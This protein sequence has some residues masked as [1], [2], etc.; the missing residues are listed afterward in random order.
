MCIYWLLGGSTMKFS[1]RLLSIFLIPLMMLL[2]APLPAEAASAAVPVDEDHFPDAYFLSLV[3]GYDK[4]GS[5]YLS[6]E[7]IAAVTEM[8][9]SS[10]AS[11]QGISY[12]TSLEKLEVYSSAVTSLD[13]S[14]L[15]NLECLEVSADL[16]ELNLNGLVN[17]TKLDCRGNELTSLNLRSNTAL[18]EVYCQEN[19]LTSLRMEGLTKLTALD[20]EDNALTTLTLSDLTALETL[21]CGKNALTSLNLRE[22]RSLKELYCD[23]NDLGSLDLSA[24]SALES[25]R[26]FTNP[27]TSLKLGNLSAMTTLSCSSMA[28]TSLDVSGLPN[29]KVLY[30]NDNQLKSLDVCGLSKLQYLECYN[31]RLTSLETYG[32]TSLKELRCNNNQLSV[33]DISS[34]ENLTDLWAYDNSLTTLN[35]SALPVF[36]EL[37]RTGKYIESSDGRWYGYQDQVNLVFMYVD[38]NV[39]IDTEKPSGIEICLENFPDNAFCAHISANFDK[40]GDY[41]LSDEEIAAVTRIDGIVTSLK[42]F[43][44]IEHFTALTYISCQLTDISSLDL[45]GNPAVTYLNCSGCENLTSLDLSVNTALTELHCNNC[46][47][48][49]LNINGCS[50][51]K[52]L[53]CCNNQLTSLQLG[54]MN[55]LKTL[56]CQENQLTRLD[57]RTAP[58]ILEAVLDGTKYSS[59]IYDSYVNKDITSS[60]HVDKNVEL[61]TASK[62]VI[63]TQPESATAAEGGTANFRVTAGG[64][65]L[66]YQWQ[67]RT[68]TAGSWKAATATGN[69]TAVLK[70]P[71]TNSRNGYQ[72]RCVV[73]NAGGTVY[74][75]AVTL[76]VTPAKPVITGQPESATAAEGG[77]ANFRVTAGGSGL[78]YQWQ[79]RTG[80]AGSWKAATATGN[81]TAVLKVPATN[82]RNGYQYRCVVKNAGG[83]VYSKAAVLTVSVTVKTE[84]ASDSSENEEE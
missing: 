22:N 62:P 8:R 24:C 9:V 65:G 27:M 21:S 32:C 52:H 5:G 20:C 59:D 36:C 35:I 18:E 82:S 72:Y 43:E 78:S 29:L 63:K 16:T 3:S 67:Y 39:T 79:Y 48:K 17:L 38:K 49:D 11:L 57:L 50:N 46:G 37:I 75:K 76:T 40:D 60:L 84:A 83:T 2:F 56:A 74:S 42:S 12:F 51:L 10:G 41:Y 13:L 44:G 23:D 53:D 69:K 30:C 6:S 54:N 7:E 73:K 81:K 55:Q 61:V 14:G 34:L 68:G 45:S 1:G 77:T 26:C 25:C 15:V 19:A 58:L 31:N 4:D 70:V 28:L 80:T 64:S 66:S 47:L 33:I 71:A